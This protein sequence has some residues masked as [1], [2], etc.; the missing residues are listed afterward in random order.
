[1]IKRQPFHVT[2]IYAI[3]RASIEQMN[4]LAHQIK[5]TIIPENHVEIMK[6]WKTRCDEIGFDQVNR[7]D[8]LTDLLDQ[9]KS[10]ET[11]VKRKSFKDKT[12]EKSTGFVH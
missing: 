1:M 11:S 9:M 8:V 6:A 10:P 12:L 3:N 2:I 7:T 4:S 5:E